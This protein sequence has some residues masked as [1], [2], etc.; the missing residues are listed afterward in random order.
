M[1]KSLLL[2]DLAELLMVDVNALDDEY[3]LDGDGNWDS[4]CVVST[5]GAIDQR[6]DVIVTGGD[7]ME[8][9]SIGDIFK[10]IEAKPIIS[11]SV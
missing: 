8:C 5:V 2:N 4:L 1:N 9:R 6:Y 11:E 3:A 7:L 10:F